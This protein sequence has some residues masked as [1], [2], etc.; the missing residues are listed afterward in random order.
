MFLQALD[1]GG[2]Y[3]TIRHVISRVNPQ[4]VQPTAPQATPKAVTA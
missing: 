2:K 4:G 3:G 1:A